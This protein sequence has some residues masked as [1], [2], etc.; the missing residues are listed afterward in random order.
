MLILAVIWVLILGVYHIHI[1]I[2]GLD[3]ISLLDLIDL[4]NLTYLNSIDQFSQKMFLFDL[5]SL[6]NSIYFFNPIKGDVSDSHLNAGGGLFWPPSGNQW[7]IA[8]RPL[9]AKSYFETYKIYDH[10][11]E[12]RPISKKFTEI[13]K[14]ENFYITRFCC[15]LA[16]GNCRSLLNFWDTKVIFG[17]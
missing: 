16:Y 7:R 2:W 4:L 8:V 12:I 10:M 11:Q 14:F 13:L 3:L 17:I 15:T 6:I 9:I 1:T 5:I